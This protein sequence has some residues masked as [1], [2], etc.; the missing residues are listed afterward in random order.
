MEVPIGWGARPMVEDPEHGWVVRQRTA[1]VVDR[2][3]GEPF[4]VMALLARRLPA[5]RPRDRLRAVPEPAHPNQ[6]GGGQPMNRTADRFDAFRRLHDQKEPLL[7]PNAWDF[8]SAA[9]LA[10]QGFPAIGTTS[11]GVAVA[12]GKR[13]AAG[14]TRDETLALARR[15]SG[16]CLVTVDLEAGF[17]ER[18]PAVAELAAELA[19]AGIV[20]VN[21]EDGRAGGTLAPI[22]RQQELIAVVAER[23]PGLFINARVDSYWIGERQPSL[24]DAI[25]RAGAYQAAG[26]SGIFVPGAPDEPTIRALVEAVDL[27]LN[28]L[29]IP[30]LFGLGRLAEL[31]V[32]RVSCGSLL[33][34]AALG[35]AVRTVLEI[36]DGGSLQAAG[37]PTYAEAQALVTA[38]G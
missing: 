18:P 6:P 29:F 13:D 35:T 19:R 17:D 22:E 3:R 5:R 27:P 26:A 8:A 16:L 14:D 4:D 36:R 21:L 38:S 20:G 1:A 2:A 23:V 33:F 37:I 30:G 24:E 25:R 11:L 34:R 10:A 32:R 9:A 31:G 7:L 12:A 28:L 15:I